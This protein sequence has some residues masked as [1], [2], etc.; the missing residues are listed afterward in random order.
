MSYK[1]IGFKEGL[2]YPHCRGTHIVLWGKRKNIQRYRCKECQKLFNDL[3]GTPLA[4]PKKTHKWT[5][6]VVTKYLLDYL[7]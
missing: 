7:I 4:Y 2:I 3:T 5:H 1:L 6:G